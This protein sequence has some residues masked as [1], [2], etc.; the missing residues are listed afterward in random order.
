MGSNYSEELRR[1][2]SMNYCVLATDHELRRME[3]RLQK[4]KDETTRLN[5]AKH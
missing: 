4:G 1:L 5:S 2:M 3:K